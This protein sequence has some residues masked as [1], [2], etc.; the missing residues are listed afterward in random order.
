VLS[1][2]R[3]LGRRSRGEEGVGLA[4]T[5]AIVTC[6]VAVAGLLGRVAVHE[7][8]ATGTDLRRVQALDA[9]DAG[10]A[11]ALDRLAADVD[12]TGALGI[13]L[14]GPTVDIAVT[15]LP[16]AGT[17]E[18]REV[19]ATGRSAAAGTVGV[20]SRSVTAVV[21]IS[22]TTDGGTSGPVLVGAPVWSSQ[23]VDL[24]SDVV[25]T[26][27]VWVGATA[28]VGARA[29]VGGSVGAGQGVTLTGQSSVDGDVRAGAGV[30]VGNQV[31]VGGGVTAAGGDVS[32][33]TSA[34]V[35]GTAAASAGVTSQGAVGGGVD[36]SNGHVTL[37]PG[38]T[39]G[40]GV[41]AGQ[42]ATVEAGASV[43]GGGV[44]AA[45]GWVSLAGPVVG[46]VATAQ[47]VDVQA[48]STVTGS[49]RAGSWVTVSG[50]VTGDVR[51]AQGVTVQ[52]AGAVGGQQIAPTP[53]TPTPLAP[54]APVAPATA[55][56]IQCTWDP[57]QHPG[58]VSWPGW[59]LSTLD[60]SGGQI[61][62][63]HR[64][65]GWAGLGGRDVVLTG[66]TTLVLEA[67]GDLPRGI[68][69]AVGPVTL[70][71]LALGGQVNVPG[72]AVWSSDVVAVIH[73]P[74][75]GL[76]IGSGASL[77]GTVIA[78]GIDVEQGATVTAAA[79]A[80]PPTGCSYPAGS[81]RG[82]SGGGSTTTRTATLVSW[83][84]GAPT[85]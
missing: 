5:M 51:S 78:S 22:A 71:V 8:R 81:V 9:A 77:H 25:L 58:Y 53:L 6:V 27:D 57:S 31:V 17:T 75:G 42:G 45:A 66:D 38:A 55:A 20:Q 46:D 35:G 50:T 4:M 56:R 23:H 49:V 54:P 37:H 11:V 10:I 28:S 82:G 80:T 64:I 62:G 12:W 69:S 76:R 14:H 84:E 33:G 3:A 60:A 63:T 61:S 24:A 19:V 40:A 15:A 32:V 16:D 29:A 74:S 44:S 13:D 85:P 30:A 47:G 36:A 79:P 43:Q 7:V 1:A 73:G 72:S 83:Q 18:V 39:V 21:H 48:T 70:T 34:S 52:G 68:T 67:G 2:L 59:D 26:D 65:Q 41:R